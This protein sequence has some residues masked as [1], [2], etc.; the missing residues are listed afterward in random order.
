MNRARID[1]DVAA[2]TFNLDGETWDVENNVWVLGDDKECV[3]IDAPHRA[4]VIDHLVGQRRLVAVLTTHGHDDHITVAPQVAGQHGAAV[5]LHP[6]DDML[7]RLS[8][9][10]AGYVPIRDGE[11][12]RVAGVEVH[13]LHTPGHLP[14]SVSYAVP[15]LGVVFSGDT[16]FRGG[17]GATHR[18][19]GDFATIIDS[20]RGKLF[21]LSP[22]TRVLTGHGDSTTIA[23]ETPHLAQWIVRG[24]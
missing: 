14:G 24:H 2:G 22:H 3:A 1:H 19:F 21:A 4:D 16:L 11:L 13:A 6:D 18:S 23:D 17:P 5:R 8:H 7:W 15:S 9:P 12:I 10:A 20:I